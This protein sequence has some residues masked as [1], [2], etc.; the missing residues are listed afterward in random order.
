M[1]QMV[2]GRTGRDHGGH[3]D[4]LIAWASG[5][6]HAAAWGSAAEAQALELSCVDGAPVLPGA[7]TAHTD[8]ILAELLARATEPGGLLDT[9]AGAR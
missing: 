7:I 4:E 8:A 5:P 2:A 9:L 6:R 1:T 3:H